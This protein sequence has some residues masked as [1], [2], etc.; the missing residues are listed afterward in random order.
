MV[1]FPYFLLFVTI[2]FCVP[3]AQMTVALTKF[4]TLRVSLLAM[5][6]PS[7]DSKVSVDKLIHMIKLKELY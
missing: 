6:N 3:F 7:L 1:C 4:H 2:C 5:L